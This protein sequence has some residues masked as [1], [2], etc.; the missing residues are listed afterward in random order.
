MTT[1]GKKESTLTLKWGVILSACAALSVF[2]LSTLLSHE[3]RI[4][5]VE[6][7]NVAIL[8]IVK[9]IKCDVKD[10]LKISKEEAKH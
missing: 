7:N 4:T 8:E 9:E 5:V 3:R 2:L 10:H 6:T 1:E